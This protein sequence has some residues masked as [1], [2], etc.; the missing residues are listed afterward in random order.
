MRRMGLN[1]NSTP[2]PT[3]ALHKPYLSVILILECLLIALLQLIKR[4][5]DF[6]HTATLQNFFMKV[7]TTLRCSFLLMITR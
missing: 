1:L 5:I 6:L 2:A 7:Q 3:V 4:L